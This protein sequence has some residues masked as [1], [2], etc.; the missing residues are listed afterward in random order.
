MALGPWHAINLSAQASRPFQAQVTTGQRIVGV[1]VG[2]TEAGGKG[3]AGI[4]CCPIPIGQVV[5]NG[6]WKN[7]SRIC[8]ESIG[9]TREDTIKICK[10]D[11]KHDVVFSR[12]PQKLLL[13][14]FPLTRPMSFVVLEDVAI[15]RFR[16]CPSPIDQSFGRIHVRM[17]S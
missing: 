13:A 1:P 9:S 8:E 7:D 12:C 17:K 2:F 5:P 6:Q 11:P 16:S 14:E 10:K 3:R 15:H 4:L